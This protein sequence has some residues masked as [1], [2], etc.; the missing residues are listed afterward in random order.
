MKKIFVSVVAILVSGLAVQA[1]QQGLYSNFLLNSYVFNPA[2]AGVEDHMD[3]KTSFRRQ[4]LDLPGSPTTMYASLHGAVNQRD[5]NK[6][7]LG[8]LPMR[9]ASTIKFKN[10][11]PMKIRHGVGGFFLNDQAGLINHNLISLGYSIHLPLNQKYYLAIGANLGA[12]LFNLKNPN[13]RDQGDD[14]FA[15]SQS[16][17]TLPDAQFGFYLYS[18]RLQ[19][20]LSGTQLVANRMS[21]AA[22]NKSVSYNNLTRHF[23]GTVSYRISLDPD[24]DLL[25]VAI[26]RY[27]DN[28]PLSIEAGGKIRYRNTF[29]AGGTYRIGDAATGMVGLSLYR[30]LDLSY[31]FD[32]TTTQVQK[33]SV[34]THEIVLGLRLNNKKPNSSLKVW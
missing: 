27:T 24:F 21:F 19:I 13:L 9:G 17:G 20:G 8:S 2:I 16:F 32:F 29:W 25:P 4:W 11:A 34:G 18:D 23:Y 26:A 33:S 31:A 7:E 28:S 12:H 10:V 1:Q 5:L 30:F 6:E 3:L 22:N 15:G 14:A